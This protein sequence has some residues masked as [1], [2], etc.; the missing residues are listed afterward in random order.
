MTVEHATVNYV[1][2]EYTNEEFTVI[3]VTGKNLVE[4]TVEGH[5]TPTFTVISGGDPNGN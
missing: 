2:R 1:I 3:D 5:D 4:F